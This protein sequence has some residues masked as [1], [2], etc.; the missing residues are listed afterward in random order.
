MQA[1]WL[2]FPLLLLALVLTSNSAAAQS[3]AD[4]AVSTAQPTESYQGLTSTSITVTNDGPHC[5]TVTW[6]E[7]DDQSSHEYTI[8][9]DGAEHNLPVKHSGNTIRDVT[10][11]ICSGSGKCASGHI[12]F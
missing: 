2:F 10:I 12:E 5:I 9:A 4:W 7:S 1:K 3:G 6:I 11:K 8:P